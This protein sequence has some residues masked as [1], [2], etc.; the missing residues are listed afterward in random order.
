ML[1]YQHT[2]RELIRYIEEHKLEYGHK[3]PN[4]EEMMNQFQ[5]SKN[6]VIK[7]LDELERHGIIYQ[8]RGSGIFV[9]GHRRTGYI[10]LVEIHGFNSALREFEIDSIVLDLK[11]VKATP[12]VQAN[13]QVDGEQD[14]Y[15]VKRLRSIEGRIFCIEESYYNKD[16]V[17][18]LNQEIASDSIFSYLVNDLKLKVGFLDH[19]LRVRKLSE[20]EAGHLTLKK[21]DPAATVESI[22]YL[23]NGQAFD[24]SKIVYHYEEA[25]F[26]IQGNS[27]YN[28]MSSR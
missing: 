19:F 7:A 18:Y 3:L 25:Q 22:F 21:D 20:E 10:N 28:L 5:V 14:V 6:T 12:E 9:R 16:I 26:F 11:V 2:A 15:Y 23:S 4:I 13:L 1:K 24:Y 8:V 17:P 27:Y